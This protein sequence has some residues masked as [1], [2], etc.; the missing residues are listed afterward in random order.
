MHA[1]RGGVRL[2]GRY[3]QTG[4]PLDEADP[5]LVQ[6]A[7]QHH[8][9]IHDPA[10]AEALAIKQPGPTRAKKE[11]D[12]A[13]MIPSYGA[14]PR[15]SYADEPLPLPKE[16]LKTQKLKGDRYIPT[17]PSEVRKWL[18]EPL[19]DPSV[20]SDEEALFFTPRAAGLLISTFNQLRPLEEYTAGAK[21]GL[22]KRGWYEN[23]AK[24]I[25]SVFGH[26]ATRFAALLAATSPRQS[27][28]LN[29]RKS[30][31]IWTQFQEW[32]KKRQERGRPV[33]PRFDEALEF[34]KSLR[35][36]GEL[37]RFEHHDKNVALALSGDVD[38]PFF[39]LSGPKVNSFRQDLMK[40]QGGL[41]NT[42]HAD[43]Y[44]K[45]HGAT[46]DVWEARARRIPQDKFGGSQRKHNHP[47]VLGSDTRLSVGRIDPKYLAGIVK[48]RLAAKQLNAERFAGEKP[49]TAYEV[50]E[51]TWSMFRGLAAYQAM[52]RRGDLPGGVRPVFS[53]DALDE[54]THGFISNNSDFL[55]LLLDDPDARR[56][57]EGTAQ[58]PGLV[59][60]NTMRLLSKERERLEASRTYP[61][62]GRA[63]S[64][65]Q[66]VRSRD[67]A[68]AVGQ[69]S[70]IYQGGFLSGKVDYSRR[71][72]RRYAAVPAGAAP[73]TTPHAS[74]DSFIGHTDETDP[75]LTFQQ[76]HQRAM[77]SQGRAWQKTSEEI[78]KRV[79]FNHFRSHIG[80]GDWQGSAEHSVVNILPGK[81]DYNKIR[82][83]A[84]WHGLT[85]N[86]LAV[87]AFHHDPKGED[88]T[89][90]TTV[91]E[92]D[93]GAVR[94]ILDQHGIHDRTLIPD[95]HGTRVIYFD[96]G[97]EKRD[98]FLQFAGHYNAAVHEAPGR[99]EFIGGPTRSAARRAYREIIRQHEGGSASPGP[100]PLQPG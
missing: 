30:L 7:G 94:R 24:A 37:D 13:S 6:E 88:S 85:A 93:V 74:Q 55:T 5:A 22:A 51:T 9:L 47:E 39:V 53:H 52:A 69:E 36:A 43:F 60:K 50:Q 34:V 19:S 41:E 64:S 80:V 44:S 79:G 87:L 18:P 11:D 31:Q 100:S 90:F 35:K 89:Y 48:H 92:T 84:A 25:Y 75:T 66:S 10:R 78:L 83:A 40:G 45:L 70:S 21:V 3:F 62:S 67:A 23:A 26:N 15:P 16:L 61:V 95:E 86:Q 82:L 14:E 77:S 91:P 73:L 12:L 98:A 49:W 27:V 76:A 97:R 20:I 29:L 81:S 4:E 63:A 54:I 2:A 17:S 1:P 96:G 68:R 33:Y 99:G 8:E 42:D 32:Q 28:K 46:L 59:D 58:H 38:D 57:L 56:L 71:R 65:L 72:R